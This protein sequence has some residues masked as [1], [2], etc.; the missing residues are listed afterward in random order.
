MGLGKEEASVAECQW[1]PS[2]PLLGGVNCVSYSCGP[3]GDYRGCDSWF[4]V[5]V[6]GTVHSAL[7][8]G[9]TALGCALGGPLLWAAWPNTDPHLG[10]GA[11]VRKWE[12]KMRLEK[13][14]WVP[15]THLFRGW[16]T[17]WESRTICWRARGFE[18][19][20]KCKLL[21]I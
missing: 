16:Q 1:E 19:L 21:H 11:L 9:R 6:G 5:L 10:A 14:M 2:T 7:C 13:D 3:V 12:E 17:R 18:K 15:Q 20:G 4:D 8:Q